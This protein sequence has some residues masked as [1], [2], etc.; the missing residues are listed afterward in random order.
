MADLIQF[1]PAS[2]KGVVI[3]MDAMIAC[4]EGVNPSG[5]VFI[6]LGCEEPIEVLVDFKTFVSDWL[7]VYVAKT[8]KKKPR[9]AKQQGSPPAILSGVKLEAS[10]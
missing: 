5:T 6:L 9:R 1:E 3:D 2:G 8:V 4:W 7:D 10:A